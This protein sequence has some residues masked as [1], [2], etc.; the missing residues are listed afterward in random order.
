MDFATYART[1]QIQKL[2][3][4]IPEFTFSQVLNENIALR[5][6]LYNFKTNSNGEAQLD[7]SYID[8]NLASLN[9]RLLIGG[10]RLAQLLNAVLN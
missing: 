2:G 5:K 3:Y 10:M 6:A 7:Q 9:S 8:A 4:D 1:L